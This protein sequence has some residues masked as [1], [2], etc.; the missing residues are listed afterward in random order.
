MILASGS[1]K[2]RARCPRKTSLVQHRSSLGIS[3]SRTIMQC[4][5]FN[6]D[7]C[8]SDL[9]RACGPHVA[10]SKAIYLHR[11]SPCAFSLETQMDCPF[12]LQSRGLFEMNGVWG[13][14]RGRGCYLSCSLHFV[15][16]KL[17]LSFSRAKDQLGLPFDAAQV[18]L[19]SPIHMCCNRS[20][21][22]TSLHLSWKHS[23]GR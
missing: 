8:C 17:R 19:G 4:T 12:A 22:L 2:G 18:L 9:L 21:W 11:I 7:P 20:L 3:Y 5:Q 6:L 23:L 1:R 13:W 10:W 14:G 16:K 15:E